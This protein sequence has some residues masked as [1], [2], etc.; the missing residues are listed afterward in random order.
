MLREDS[1]NPLSQYH[2]GTLALDANQQLEDP[3]SDCDSNSVF[4]NKRKWKPATL[5]TITPV[6]HDSIIYRFSLWP[7]DMPL[8]LPVGQHVFVRLRRKGA[9]VEND[10]EPGEM[11]QRAYTPVSKYDAHGHVDLL[12]K[13]VLPT[14]FI[15]HALN[16]TLTPMFY[17]RIYHP[18]KAF[19]L[20]G[21]MTMGFHELEIGDTIELKGP[22]GSFVYT[23][24]RNITYRSVPQL[25]I[26][27]LG[28]ICGGS[29]IT[30]I[31]QVL[32]AVIRDIEAGEPEMKIWI[33]DANKTEDD[34]L[35][36]EEL[37]E[38]LV[39]H[40]SVKG[41]ER[42]FLHHI[43]SKPPPIWPESY[44]SGRI[45]ESILQNHLPPP[46]DDTMILIC[47][48]DGMINHTVK[49]GLTK[50]GWDI[51]KSLVVF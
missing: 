37:D 47:G 27:K 18:S 30:P 48:P 14:Q 50:L 20:G 33:I 45:T 21:K 7:P 8:G 3:N 38:Y 28:M 46:S 5:T 4:L 12:I 23:E 51:E 42:V 44:G 25:G 29:G 22:L 16:A 36:R 6:S 31:L 9:G 24:N 11:V 41:S 35:C 17:Q 26:K 34:I 15:F 32:R 10:G 13:L 19:P 2:I 1:T 39:S 43:L 49:P 40:G